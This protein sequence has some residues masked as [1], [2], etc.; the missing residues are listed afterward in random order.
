MPNFQSLPLRLAESP[1]VHSLFNIV[2]NKTLNKQ[3]IM[4]TLMNSV[5]NGAFRS[6]TIMSRPHTLSPNRTSINKYRGKNGRSLSAAGSGRWGP[7]AE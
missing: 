2:C 3:T 4:Y 5:S 1:F 7:E 6:E